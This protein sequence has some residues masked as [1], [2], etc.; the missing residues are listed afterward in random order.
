MGT[1]ICEIADCPEKTLTV[2]V[3]S[4][5]GKMVLTAVSPISEGTFPL[6]EIL[7]DQERSTAT[8]LLAYERGEDFVSTAALSGSESNSTSS[9][10]MTDQRNMKHSIIT[11]LSG[12]CEETN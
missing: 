11:V 6:G 2:D 4:S 7:I 5:E 1:E 10:Q 8:T 3:T 12:V 9:F